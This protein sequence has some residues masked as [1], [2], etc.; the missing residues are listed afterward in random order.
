VSNAKREGR[1]EIDRGRFLA[2]AAAIA[3]VGC[4]TSRG[5]T[6]APSAKRS[7]EHLPDGRAGVPPA[8][9]SGDPSAPPHTPPSDDSPPARENT[10]PIPAAAVAAMDDTEGWRA[11]CRTRLGPTCE[12]SERV[13][14]LCMGLNEF[15]VAEVGVDAMQCMKGLQDACY[16]NIVDECVA[17][18]AQAWAEKL[19]HRPVSRCEALHAVI[20]DANPWGVGSCTQLYVNVML[21]RGAMADQPGFP[22]PILE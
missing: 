18:L 22:A 16:E 1:L 7:A 6:R 13:L 4:G 2:Y 21:R 10:I 11:Y 3:V 15:I 8:V 5:A 9:A 12:S 17:P 14:P 19:A 20:L